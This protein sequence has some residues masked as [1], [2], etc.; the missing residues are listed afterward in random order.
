MSRFFDFS[1]YRRTDELLRPAEKRLSRDFQSTENIQLVYKRA[2]SEVDS[3]PTYADVTS[4]MDEVFRRSI[5][6]E[7]LPSVEEMNGLVL[8]NLARAAERLS[9][10]QKRYAERTF[11]NSNIPTRILP[12]PSYTSLRDG[13]GEK[14]GGDII[15]LLRR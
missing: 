7:E 11:S 1:L 9:A 13:D 15:E 2:L 5:Q 4:A 12:R 3:G 8:L 6:T 14:E 10:G